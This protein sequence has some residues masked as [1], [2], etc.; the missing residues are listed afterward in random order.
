MRNHGAISKGEETFKARRG[1]EK[2]VVFWGKKVKKVDTW[3]R[4]RDPGR[5]PSLHGGEKKRNYV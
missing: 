2:I 5:P 3:G 4:G 1:G